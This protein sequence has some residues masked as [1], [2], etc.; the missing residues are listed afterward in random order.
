MTDRSF[1][2]AH[3]IRATF[4]QALSKMYQEEVPLYGDLLT[5]VQES[6]Q[7]ALDQTPALKEQ[8][9][10][11]D[12]LDR[13][14]AERHG[15]IR[16]GSARELFN[17]RR[18]FALMGM[19]PV[20]YYDLSTAGL[21]VHSTAFRPL[22]VDELNANPLRVF[23]S[24]LR[25]D[26]ITN[27]SLRTRAK[28]LLDH[29]QIFSP[30]TLELIDNHESQKGLT[31]SQT[32]IFI[33][34]ALHTFRWHAQATVDLETYHQY[35]DTHPLIAD[36]VCFQGPHINHLTPRTLDI[37]ACQQAMLKRSMNPKAIIEGPP[38]RDVPVLLRQTSFKALNEAIDF[39]DANG[40]RQTGSH[41]ARFGEIEQRGMALTPKGRQLYDELLNEVHA[42][43]ADSQQQ[44]SDYYHNLETVFQRFPDDSQEIHQQALGYFNYRL[45]AKHEINADDNLEDL[46]SSGRL[47]LIAITYE[48][49]LPVSAAGIFRSNLDS[50]GD[51]DFKRKPNQQAFERDLGCRVISEF[52]LY[53]K[54][55]RDSLSVALQTDRVTEP[56]R[57]QL[58]DQFEQLY[59]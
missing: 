16:L 19:H 36:I 13:L 51:S 49:F 44:I 12:T 28:K 4:A 26:L 15:A 41:T 39:T 45:Q 40:H 53:Y 46:V 18:L 24:L 34:E 3:E 23:T 43:A 14:S 52:D 50:T 8:T 35:L 42:I 37:D 27:E 17:M 59:Q 38:K 5:L 10:P 55:Q 11:S 1:V 57:A 48:D 30:R 2:P 47:A 7:Q 20:A 21:P 58:M 33:V 9:I 56:K 25:L 29:R 22:T 6:N 32:D 54:M 31:E